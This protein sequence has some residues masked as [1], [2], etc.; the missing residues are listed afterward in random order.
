MRYP[1]SAE[2]YFYLGVA[3]IKIGRPAAPWT[4][5]IQ[6]DQLFPRS[7]PAPKKSWVSGRGFM[8]KP[9]ITVRYPPLS[10]R[11][12]RLFAPDPRVGSG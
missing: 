8:Q 3:T 2:A 11:Q 12:E 10:R 7:T 9:L 5:S 6:C 1:S 4:N